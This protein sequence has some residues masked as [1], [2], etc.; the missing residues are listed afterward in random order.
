MEELN[1]VIHLIFFFTQTLLKNTITMILCTYI[2]T[3]TPLTFLIEKKEK[4]RLFDSKFF[5]IRSND[6]YVGGVL[7]YLSI[8]SKISIPYVPKNKT[9][10]RNNKTK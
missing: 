1:W 2:Y 9:R 4:K 8:S 7:D 6:H 5:L 3:H 10:L